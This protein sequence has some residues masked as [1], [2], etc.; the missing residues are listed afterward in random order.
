[1]WGFVPNGA[2]A[3]Y[4]NRSQPPL[5]SAMVA[6]VVEATAAAEEEQRENEHKAQ[7]TTTG[8]SCNGTRPGSSSDCTNSSTGGSGEAEALLRAALPRLI[9]QHGYWT[10]GRKVVRVRSAGGSGAG[11]GAGTNG[12]GGR[13]GGGSCG[14]RVYE[15]SRYHAELYEPRPESFR[16]AIECGV[17]GQGLARHAR[18]RGLVGVPHRRP[19]TQE[20]TWRIVCHVE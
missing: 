13:G 1:V 7:G 5:L 17:S 8:A 6:A 10:S 11:N 12:S 14:D 9:A 20:C 15:L 16:C 3:Y 18:S 4:T 2:R 19:G